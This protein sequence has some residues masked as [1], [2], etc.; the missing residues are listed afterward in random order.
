MRMG[1]FS[2]KTEFRQSSIT[3]TLSGVAMF[4]KTAGRIL[5]FCL[6]NRNIH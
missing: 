6:E 2:I 1:S 3:Y 4:L 5:V